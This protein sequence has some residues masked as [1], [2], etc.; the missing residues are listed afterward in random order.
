MIVVAIA[1]VSLACGDS[2]GHAVVWDGWRNL[3]FIGPGSRRDRGIDGTVL[4]NKADQAGYMYMYHIDMRMLHTH[5]C[6]HTYTHVYMCT[7]THMD[8]HT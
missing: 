4:V 6:T 3:L 8:I 5:T 1:V 2:C 7:C